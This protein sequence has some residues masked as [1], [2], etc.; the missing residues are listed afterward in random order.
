MIILSILVATTPERN[1]MF[2]EL[3][4]ELHKQLEYMNTFHPSLGNIEILVDDSKRYLDGGLSIGKKRE[5]LLKRASG[6]YICYLDSDE[7]ISGNYLETLV[8]ACHHDKDIVTFR[9]F[10]NLEQYWTLI[11]M[12]LNYENEEATP[13]KVTQRLP[14]HICPVKLDYAKIYDFEDVNYGEDWKWF[15]QVLKHCK[16]EYHMHSILH[17]YNHGSHSQADEITR[18]ENESNRLG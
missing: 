15:E 13:N 11:D 5:A 17:Q 7:S 6:K 8:R 18:Y 16:T 10:A 3:F 14:W 12:S 2:T 1:E 4:N 9:S